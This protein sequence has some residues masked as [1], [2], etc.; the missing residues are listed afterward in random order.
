MPKSPDPCSQF[1]E[2]DRETKTHDILK[3]QP[4]ELEEDE[5]EGADTWLME[6]V[7]GI[8]NVSF[9]CKLKHVHTSECTLNP[10]LPATPSHTSTRT[11]TSGRLRQWANNDDVPCLR[12]H[13]DR[14]TVRLRRRSVVYY[15]GIKSFL[16]RI[17]NDIAD[18]EIPLV[19]VEE[20][21]RSSNHA[22]CSYSSYNHHF[23]DPWIT[24]PVTRIL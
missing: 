18:Q 22:S 17:F 19:V 10:F 5:R 4:I 23:Y 6:N 20:S 15:Y 8:F 24:H 13:G 21:I 11:H 14:W 2:E 3:P 12:H 16:N 7:A 1:F 9:F